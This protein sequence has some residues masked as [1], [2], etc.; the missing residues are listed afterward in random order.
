MIVYS[1]TI[2]FYTGTPKSS[3]EQLEENVANVG[4]TIRCDVKGD[5]NCFFYSVEDQLTRLGLEARTASQLRKD[6]VNYIQTLVSES[7][8]CSCTKL[9]EC[10][11]WRNKMEHMVHQLGFKKKCKSLTYTG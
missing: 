9:I 6:V 2:F 1:Y 10:S 3:R 8:G 11:I 5:G 7:Y 4:M